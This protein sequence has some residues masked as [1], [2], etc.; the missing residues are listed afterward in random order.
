MA[1]NS[2]SNR[3][4][5]L[6]LLKFYAEAGPV[7]ALALHGETLCLASAGRIRAVDVRSGDKVGEFHG[8]N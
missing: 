5:A 1:T 8:S 2:F 3:T 6:M 4:D 7:S